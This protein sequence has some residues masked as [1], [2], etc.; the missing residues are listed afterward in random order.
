MRELNRIQ[1]TEP[2]DLHLDFNVDLNQP[3]ASQVTAR[4]HGN[5]LQYR[6]L[7]VDSVAV[8]VE[9]RDGAIIV[10]HC[11]AT[12]YGGD[13]AVQGRYDIGMGQFDVTFSSSTDPAAIIPLFIENAL[14]SSATCAWRTIRRSR[15]TTV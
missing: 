1:V 10:R 15:P 13:V 2:P 7:L 8:N 6:D 5:H 3:L 12:L 4:F 9:M 14:R 11:D